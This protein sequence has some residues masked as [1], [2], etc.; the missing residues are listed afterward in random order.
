[1]LPVWHNSDVKSEISDIMSYMENY[2]TSNNLRLNVN[3]T[4]VLPI[5]HRLNASLDMINHLSADFNTVSELRYLGLIFT[6]N[7][8]WNCHI[9][10]IVK[11]SSCRLHALRIL[12]HA[13]MPTSKLR[14]VYY[15][16]IRQMLEY[17]CMVFTN[18]TLVN[19]NRLNQIQIRAHKIICNMNCT[20]TSLESLDDRRIR[21][22]IRF[23]NDMFNIDHPLHHIIPNYLPSGRL[24]MPYCRTALRLNSF[25][26]FNIVEHNQHFNRT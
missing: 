11:R 1:M 18:L 25:L 22:S 4:K 3:K 13:N 2:C 26:P 10:N 6:S 19:K 20:C 12:K 8:N 9:D 15:C 5:F 17:A 16:I 14:Q 24:V 21:R 7:F 23:F